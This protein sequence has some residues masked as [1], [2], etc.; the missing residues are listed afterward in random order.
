MPRKRFRR[1]EVTSSAFV[2][3]EKDDKERRGKGRI[4]L[5]SSPSATGLVSHA[6]GS[7]WSHTQRE[8]PHDPSINI[9]LFLYIKSFSRIEQTQNYIRIVSFTWAA[10]FF[11]QVEAIIVFG[12]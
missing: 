5:N 6:P 9:N 10:S 7:K 11:L 2:S 4:I 12:P 3:P 1:E 8:P